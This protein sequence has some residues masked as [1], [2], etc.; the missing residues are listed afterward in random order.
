[1][2]KKIK[3]KTWF[4]VVAPKFFEEKS[5]GE[6]PADEA[7]KVMFRVVEAPL[8]NLTNDMSKF[9]IKMK[10][11]VIK[12]EDTKAYTEFAGLECLRDYISRMIRRGIERIDTRQVLETKDGR[13]IIVKTITITNRRVTRGV[14]KTIRKFVEEKIEK[15]VKSNKLDGFLESILNDSLK[16]EIMKE[17]SKIYPLRDF[18]VRKVE[19]PIKK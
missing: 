3:G 9:Y 13:K 4:T 6:T 15:Y 5:L 8:I 11:R 17:G 2:A 18:I 1:M 7:K 10:F 12:V 16:N 14:G 19:V